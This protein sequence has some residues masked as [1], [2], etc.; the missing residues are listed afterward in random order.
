M[1]FEGTRDFLMPFLGIG[2][3]PDNSGIFNKLNKEIL[4]KYLPIFERELKENGSNG[5]LVGV[6]QTSLADIGLLEVL[7]E[8]EDWANYIGL[9]ASLQNIQVFEND[10]FLIIKILNFR[11]KSYYY[12]KKD[13]S[14]ENTLVCSNSSL[15]EW[16]T[17]TEKKR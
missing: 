10:Y 11:L 17:T 14:R 16:T 7:L 6:N 12:L 4:P 9:N 5:H 8:L 3:T 13:V 15:F 2:F 1:L